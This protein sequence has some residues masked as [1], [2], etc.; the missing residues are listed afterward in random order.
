[1]SYNY[2]NTKL[3][4]LWLEKEFSIE[5]VENWFEIDAG[6]IK[7][8]TLGKAIME[9][10]SNSVCHLLR[11]FKVLN[12]FIAKLVRQRNLNLNGRHGCSKN[13]HPN[14]GTP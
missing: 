12:D 10:H 13:Y 4:V 7:K 6:M 2:F 11:V 14:F 1:M 8:M 9:L 5:R 3:Y